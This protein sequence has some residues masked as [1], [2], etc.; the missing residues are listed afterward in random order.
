[1][2]EFLQHIQHQ[3]LSE[4]GQSSSVEKLEELSVRYLGRKSKFTAFLRELK[5]LPVDQRRQV[6]RE[7]ND[8]RRAIEHAIASR[9]SVVA[10]KNTVQSIDATVPGTTLSSGHYHPISQFLRKVVSIFQSMGFETVDGPEVESAKYNFDLL[11]IPAD[12][13]AR[14]LWD[15]YYV[16]SPK[17]QTSSSAGDQLLLR[18]H[19]SPV[20]VRTMLER[21][22]PVRIIVPGRVFRH[23]AT[24]ASHECTFYQ[25]EGLVIDK[26]IRVTDLIG[27][28][29]AFLQ[30]VY[31]EQVRI[32]VRPEYYPFVEPGLDV[33]MS[34]ILCGGKG[35]SVCKQR[36]WLE[37]LGS[38]MV[39][40]VVL[41]NMRIDPA[42]YSGFAFGLGIDRLMMLYYGIPDI[43]LA[44]SGDLRFL[45]Q[46]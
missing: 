33:D 27:T 10:R 32:R 39:H 38:G 29:K 46:F 20:Q 13:P 41:K 23:E 1:M 31:G 15:T 45:S 11:N 19:T 30:S 21:R 2:N 42:V 43:R 22:P 40:P 18:T 4:V 16:T 34:C 12:H 9:R 44:Y 24:D 28:L 5:N 3:A 26:G 17:K 35:C 14:D 37:M 25:C 7:A 8:V 36:G 6:G